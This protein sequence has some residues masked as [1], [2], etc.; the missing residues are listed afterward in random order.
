MVIPGQR[1]GT[2]LTQVGRTGCAHIPWVQG[3]GQA[4]SCRGC[5]PGINFQSS[6]LKRGFIFSLLIEGCTAGSDAE[7]GEISP[8]LG[9]SPPIGSLGEDTLPGSEGTGTG[10]AWLPTSGKLDRT[11]SKETG[12]KPGGQT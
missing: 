10:G 9:S 8:S 7:M 1:E 11:G 2:L 6:L 3:W 4:H 5:D 12:P